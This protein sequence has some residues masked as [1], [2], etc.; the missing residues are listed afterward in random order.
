M[1]VPESPAISYQSCDGEVGGQDASATTASH[2][3]S[4]VGPA[5][6]QSEKK[7][8]GCP[9]AV[10]HAVPNPG[11][12][13]G[14]G[15][16]GMTRGPG[17]EY[18]VGM[19][20]AQGLGLGTEGAAGAFLRGGSQIEGR[21]RFPTG[22][23]REAA[24]DW[25]GKDEDVLEVLGAWSLCV[26]PQAAPDRDWAGAGTSSSNFLFRDPDCRGP[27]G[28]AGGLAGGCAAV[29]N[30]DE[31]VT[32]VKGSKVARPSICGGGEMCACPC[33]SVGNESELVRSTSLL[34]ASTAYS[35]DSSNSVSMWSQ[36]SLSLASSLPFV[37]TW[38]SRRLRNSCCW[39]PDTPNRRG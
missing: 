15:G 1:A 22:S 19:L 4:V 23:S 38:A 6:S 3:M 34:S 25:N 14:K 9:D 12:A 11:A 10:G 16:G 30:G 35:T 29:F 32:G 8:R 28:Q 26:A 24:L 18:A 39:M 2:C 33:D 36:S 21:S 7:V 17:T 5:G 31:N 27:G 13:Q 20:W 37:A